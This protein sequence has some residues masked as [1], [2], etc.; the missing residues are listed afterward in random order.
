MIAPEISHDPDLKDYKLKFPD[1]L[2]DSPPSNLQTVFKSSTQFSA[3]S[4]AHTFIVS[5]SILDEGA[6]TPSV[7]NANLFI[8]QLCSNIGAGLIGSLNLKL[9]DGYSMPVP[10]TLVL[11]FSHTTGSDELSLQIDEAS[12]QIKL[13]NQSPLDLQV[14]RYALVSASSITVA[15]VPL[16]LPPGTAVP[17]PLPAEHADLSLAED[18]QLILPAPMMKADVARFLNFQ[19]VDVQETQ[20]VIAIDAGSVN[21]NKFDSIVASITFATLPTVAPQVLTLTKH[22]HADS[23]HIVIPLENAVFSLPGE[24]DLTI[25]FSDGATADLKF[26]LQNDFTVQPVLVLLQSDIDNNMAGRV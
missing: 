26:T 12:A 22:I 16:H 9:D 4:D 14:S 5:V 8:M 13:S 10:S 24:V 11:N 6:Q 19:T 1:F 15:S 3:G 18:A 23:T 25:K 17:I 20:Y 2:Q 21:F 7:A